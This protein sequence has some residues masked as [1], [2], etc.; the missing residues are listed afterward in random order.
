MNFLIIGIII[1]VFSLFVVTAFLLRPKEKNFLINNRK[2]N[3]SLN[4][5]QKKKKVVDKQLE[6]SFSKALMISQ[7]DREWFFILR[8]RSFFICSLI[9]IIG[10]CL[11]WETG[12]PINSNIRPLFVLFLFLYFGY[13]FPVFVLDKKVKAIDDDIL[14]FLPIAIEQLIVGITSGL[15]IGPSIDYVVNMAEARGTTNSVIKLFKNVQNLVK[16]G[17]SLDTA[18]HDV[19]IS[20]MNP[21]IKHA[22]LHLGQVYKHGGEVAKQLIDLADTITR[23]REVKITAIINKLEL[24]SMGPVFFVFLANMGVLMCCIFMQLMSGLSSM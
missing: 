17:S 16:S 1:I 20:S 8:R 7:D 11:L 14:Y 24:K 13:K 10:C 15:D 9:G 4:R 6:K 23:Q 19:A 2:S 22:F 21:A 18:L 5:N 3:E 12:V